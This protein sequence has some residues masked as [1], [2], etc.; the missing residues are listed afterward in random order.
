M[1]LLSGKKEELESL[2][3]YFSLCLFLAKG[4]LLV[5]ELWLLPPKLSLVSALMDCE[6]AC[7]CVCVC[8]CVFHE[9]CLSLVLHSGVL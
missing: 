9:G 6:G 2:G 8:T 3:L 1:S 5:S 4:L 7:V